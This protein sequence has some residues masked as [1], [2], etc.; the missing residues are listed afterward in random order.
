M[1]LNLYSLLLCLYK[2]FVAEFCCDIG[3]SVTLYSVSVFRFFNITS[4][5]LLVASVVSVCPPPST[6]NLYPEA[7]FFPKSVKVFQVVVSKSCTS[8]TNSFLNR[9]WNLSFINSTVISVF[10]ALIVTVLS[11]DFS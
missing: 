5:K 8:S 2:F 6:L 10:S 4:P 1:I 9:T 11:A 7:F 3:N